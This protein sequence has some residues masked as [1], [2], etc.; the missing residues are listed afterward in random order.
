MKLKSCPFC[1]SSKIEY[2]YYDTGGV[3]CQNCEA[4]IRGFS[5][6]K[7]ARQAWNTRTS[8]WILA[9][10]RLPE[11]M[12]SINNENYSISVWVVDRNNKYYHAFYY[13]PE[14]IWYIEDTSHILNNITHWQSLPMPPE[15]P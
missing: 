5:T 11:K 2:Y 6:A 1:G 4:L 7:E 13:F 3:Q 10:A 12:K 15:T 8:P 14:K 9:S